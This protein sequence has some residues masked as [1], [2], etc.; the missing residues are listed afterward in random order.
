MCAL[1]RRSS[2]VNLD[3]D[4]HCDNAIPL[5][6][7]V[8]LRLLCN[9]H[10]GRPT[11]LAH[12]R[13]SQSPPKCRLHSQHHP[14]VSGNL[15][16]QRIP[17]PPQSLGRPAT[18]SGT[19]S[20]RRRGSGTGAGPSGRGGRGTPGGRGRTPGGSAPSGPGNATPGPSGLGRGPG[21]SG[22]AVASGRGTGT[23]ARGSGAGTGRGTGK[24]APLK[25]DP[26]DCATRLITIHRLSDIA[27]TPTVFFDSQKPYL[28]RATIV[29]TALGSMPARKM[30]R[31][32]NAVTARIHEEN[33][34]L[35]RALA[36]F[37]AQQ[38]PPH[39]IQTAWFKAAEGCFGGTNFL[40]GPE[41]PMLAA[42]SS[43]CNVLKEQRMAP[44]TLKAQETAS[45][46]SQNADARV[47]ASHII[48]TIINI[49][50]IV[51]WDAELRGVDAVTEAYALIYHQINNVYPTLSGQA[52][53]KMLDKNNA[54]SF[55]TLK[56]Q[57]AKAMTARRK[58]RRLFETL[59]SG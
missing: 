55:D 18:G 54:G 38:Q 48:T 4:S 58:L 27:A 12:D 20:F 46:V 30:P 33:L 51:R 56:R 1:G 28:P 34:A 22:S 40:S 35:G 31:T 53:V 5:S 11:R 7:S 57:Y 49:D 23:A 6:H 42:I 3:C 45:S 2:A 32:M 9:E 13:R 41:D 47:F 25:D 10:P 16:A 24:N 52:L 21:A 44:F 19:G 37:S 8:I 14:R 39:R 26:A 50:L 59:F 43:Y 36:G 15:G 17:R 29:E